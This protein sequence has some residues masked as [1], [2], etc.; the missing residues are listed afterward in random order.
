MARGN[1][2]SR[3]DARIVDMKAW[4]MRN[5]PAMGSG[6]NQPPKKP[7]TKTG[8]GDSPYEKNRDDAN[9]HG[10]PRPRPK[11]EKGGFI[12]KETERKKVYG[13][14]NDDANPH[15]MPRPQLPKRESRDDKYKNGW[16]N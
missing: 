3:N 16:Y 12:S 5:H 8:G 4:K 6:G 1:D 13:D 10:M 7:S 11:E 9:P 2:E 15:G 14:N